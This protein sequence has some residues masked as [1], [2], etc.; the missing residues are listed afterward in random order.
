MIDST[1]IKL[2]TKQSDL[3]WSK[4]QE[5]ANIISLRALLCVLKIKKYNDS[6]TDNVEI[7]LLILDYI[8]D[9]VRYSI[10]GTY[11]VPRDLSTSKKSKR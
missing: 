9:Q 2:F 7:T 4:S 8:I 6:L 11:L 1:R 10:K 3:K 5:A